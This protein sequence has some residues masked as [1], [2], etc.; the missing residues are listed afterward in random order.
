MNKQI[1][2]LLITE[3]SSKRKL[4]K[5][6]YGD[7]PVSVTRTRSKTNDT[8]KSF[9]MLT[10]DE[11]NILFH[12]D[13]WVKSD[14]VTFYLKETETYAIG[15]LKQELKLAESWFVPFNYK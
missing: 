9:Y 4:A 1:K 7:L 12:F 2:R 10:F 8:V 15:D 11:C 14:D 3:L 13:T 6:L 5:S